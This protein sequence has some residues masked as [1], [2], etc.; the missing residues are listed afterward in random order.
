MWPAFWMLGDD[1]FTVGWPT[2]GE[3]DV[4]ENVGK[5]PGT[6]VGSLHS[7]GHSGSNSLHG[8]YTLPD[9]KALADDFHVYAVDWEPDSI[10][11][12]IDGRVYSTKSRTDVGGDP[13]PFGH[14]FFL[15]LNVA[16]GGSWPGS[17]D[18][19]TSLPQEMVVDYVRVYETATEA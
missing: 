7:P 2:S 14:P 19:T 9:G 6:V 17:P 15:I 4:M 3:I 10:T 18:S 12:S 16:V 5:E 13:W 8:T 11:W 1:I